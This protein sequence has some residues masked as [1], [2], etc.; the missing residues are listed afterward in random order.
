MGTELPSSSFA[1]SS[2][3]QWEYDVFLSFRGEDTRKSFTDHLY[4]ALDREG[5]STFRDDE[6]LDRGQ[7]I[8]SNLLKAIQVS[9]IALVVISRNYACSI[10]CLDELTTIVECM[11]DRGQRVFPIFYDVDPS[12]VRKQTIWFGQAFVVHEQRLK[13]DLEKDKVQKWRAAL[14]QVANLSG[15]HLQDRYVAFTN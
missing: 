1:S 5:I 4:A 7:A 11:E 10:W 13:D 3:T 14:T 12:E 8:S 2:N 15:F 9:R 6:E